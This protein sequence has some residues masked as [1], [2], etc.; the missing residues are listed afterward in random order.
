[1]ITRITPESLLGELSVWQ[2]KLSVGLGSLQT[3][4]PLSSGVTPCEVVYAQNKL[5]LFHYSCPSPSRNT[6]PLLIVYALVNRP[7]M[8]DL[9]ENRSFIKGLLDSGQQ[10]YLIDWGYPDGLDRYLTLD[11]YLNGLLDR[12]VSEICKRH[13]LKKIN[14]LGVCQGGVFSLCYSALYPQ[15]VQNLVTMV[16]PVDFHTPDNVLSHWAGVVDVDV[17]VDTLGIIPGEMLNQ[18]FVSLK[19]YRLTVQK[20]LEA[21]DVMDDKAAL[22]YFLHMEKWISDSPDQAGE[23][24]RQFVKDFVQQNKLIRGEVQIGGRQVDLKN[25][26]LPVLNVYAEQ[27]HLVPPSASVVLGDYVGTDDYTALSFKGGHIGIYVSGK[28]QKTV[29][30]AIGNWLD[31]RMS[32]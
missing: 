28:A 18:L 11:D 8:M 23:T 19:P 5:R 3:M 6:V 2:E 1:M 31:Q 20:Y 9:Q 27:D 15:R 32:V 30:P 21:L 25:I 13:S 29:P 16:T 10:V 22:R 24:F 4:P 17:L 26:T 14:V 7:Y 12:C